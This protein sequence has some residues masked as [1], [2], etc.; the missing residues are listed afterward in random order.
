MAKKLK[1]SKPEVSELGRSIAWQAEGLTFCT[2]GTSNA[3]NCCV[4]KLFST[5]YPVCSCGAAAGAPACPCVTGSVAGS[6]CLSG[7]SAN[8]NCSTGASPMVIG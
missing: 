5:I 8:G 6:G 7:T 1:Y 4:G 3:T 2:S